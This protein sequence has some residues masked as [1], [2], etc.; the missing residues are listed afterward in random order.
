MSAVRI[1][2]IMTALA[3][4]DAL[5]SLPEGERLFRFVKEA[6]GKTGYIG[7]TYVLRCAGVGTTQTHGR[8]GLLA[9]WKAAAE[10]MLAELQKERAA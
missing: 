7:G 3:A 6:E 2:R 1:Q 8:T 10:K 9:K 5:A 4:L